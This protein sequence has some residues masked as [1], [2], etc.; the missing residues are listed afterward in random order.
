VRVLVF[1]VKNNN[2]YE[3]EEPL[4]VVA[5]VQS[6]TEIT[7]QLPNIRE[8]RSVDDN[9]A[10]SVIALG[11]QV[12]A[13]NDGVTYSE[14]DVLVIFDSTCVNCTVDGLT[15]TCIVNV[16]VFLFIEN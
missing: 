1:K 12:S 6:V 14:E 15:T 9:T 10:G 13:S 2:A 8:R 3:L 16:N 4:T 5:E 7:C 11:Y